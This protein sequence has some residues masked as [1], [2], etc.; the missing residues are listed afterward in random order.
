VPVATTTAAAL[1]LANFRARISSAIDRH[2]ANSAGTVAGMAVR[3]C[4]RRESDMAGTEWGGR[5]GGTLITFGVDAGVLPSAFGGH[6]PVQLPAHPWHTG[7]A[8]PLAYTDMHRQIITVPGPDYIAS[9]SPLTD[10]AGNPLL[11][12]DGEVLEVADIRQGDPVPLLCG[13]TRAMGAQVVIT[14]GDGLGTYS[15][16]EVRPADGGRIVLVLEVA[17]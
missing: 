14:A 9:T 7:P 5:I 15:I 4:W 10:D 2:T 8:Q 11:N 12:A 6:P 3:G 1:P 17:S 13:E 16:A